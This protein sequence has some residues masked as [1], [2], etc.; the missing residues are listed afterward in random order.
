MKRVNSVLICVLFISSAV[1]L[2]GGG[3]MEQPVNKRV[4]SMDQPLVSDIY[5]ADPS[6]HVFNNKLYIYPSHDLENNIPYDNYGGQFDMKDY[7]VFSISDFNSPI[8]DHGEVLNVKN[9]PWAKKQLWAPDAAYKNGTYY[10]YF[11]AKDDENIFRIG[12][13]TSKEPYGPF[14]AEPEPIKGSFSIDP[15]VFIDDDGQAYMYFGGLSGGQLEN[16][17]N[18]SFDP[19]GE[20][21]Q[22]TEPALG[23]RVVKMV[24]NMLEFSEPVKEIKIIDNSGNPVTMR[25]QFKMF[26]EA[27]WMHKYKGIYYLSY[28]TGYSRCLVYATGTNPYGPFTWKGIIKQPVMGWTTHHSIVQFKNK[29][30]LFY[31]TAAISEAKMHLRNIKY[32]ELHYTDTGLI[33]PVD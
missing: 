16:W 24:E 7:H 6:A 33:K 25:D 13:A 17:T 22:E 2:F 18:G 1:L 27:V 20:V 21:P 32:T 8:T 19:K 26:F 14:E 23:P 10:L 28:S 4:L 15:A 3:E 11:P 12:V 29:W 9:I 30:Y 31:H 5:T